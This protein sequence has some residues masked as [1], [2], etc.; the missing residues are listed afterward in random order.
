MSTCVKHLVVGILFGWALLSFGQSTPPP[1][2]LYSTYFGGSQSDYINA[3]ASDSVGNVYVTGTSNSPNFPT[4]AGVYEP[5][6]PGPSGYQAVYVSKFSADGSLVWSTFVGPGTYQFAGATGIQVDSNQNVYIAGIFQ[7]PG[8]PT[9]RGLPSNGSVFVVKLNSTGSQLIYG[10]RMGPSSTDS[11][12]QLVLD[13][14]A[15][16][17]VTGS[18]PGGDCCNGQQTGIIGSTGGVDDFWVAE[19]NAAG[20]ALK[21]SVEIGGTGSD[22]ADGMAIDSSDKLYITGYTDSINF[23]HTAGAL[24]QQ[25]IGR[26]FVVKLDPARLPQG[27]LVYSAL[28]GNPGHS[29]NDFLAAQSIAVDPTGNAYVGAWTYSLGLFTSKW[30]FLPKAPTVPNAYVFELNSSGSSIVNGTYLG[31]ARDDYVGHVAV[32]SVGN[33]YVVGYTDSWDFLTTAYGNLTAPNSLSSGYYVK[34]NP[35]FAAVSSIELGGFTETDAYASVPD[36]AGGL[37]FAGFTG[38][39]FPTTANAYQPTYQGNY[40]GYLLHADFAGLCTGDGVAI[41]TLTPD[42]TLPERI[43]FISQASDVEAITNIAL[44]IDG[45]PAY[46]LHA[47]QFDTWLPVAPGHHTASVLAQNISG[48]RYQQQEQFTVPSESVCPL[49]PTNPSLTFCSPLN[50]AVVKSP[51]TI[52]VQANDP[53]PPATVRLYVDGKLQA[54]ITGQNGSYTYTLQLTPGIHTLNAQGTDNDPR[55]FTTNAV[56]R[57]AP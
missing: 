25:G 48:A 27:S 47:A 54:T 10:A 39:Q 31:G 34:L 16:A 17:F 35:Q 32:D 20:T 51:L 37:W 6:Y 8:F 2:W 3:A 49:N 33:T 40:D 44:A 12:P 18:G 22:E 15:D 1:S 29:S 52:Q 23:P 50:A 21:W 56:A 36:G 9:T 13:S 4:T 55:F 30:A 5:T 28:A 19:I 46:S 14:D 42:S 7:D 45:M 43:H 53:I 57:V 24:N 26:T 11:S 41:C 38:S